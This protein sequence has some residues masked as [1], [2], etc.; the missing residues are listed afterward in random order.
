[1]DKLGTSESLAD[2]SG[3]NPI[4]KVSL[5]HC[6]SIVLS[7]FP[8]DYS[9]DSEALERSLRE[10]INYYRHSSVGRRCLGVVHQINTP[11]QVLSFQLD[12]LEQAAQEELE[13]ISQSP[14]AESE[15]LVTLSIYRQEK[16]RQLRG[17]IEKLRN[18]SRSL[19]LQGMH[20]DIGERI[21]LDL[22]QLC[23]QE[24]D[25]YLTNPIFKHQVTKKF[26]FGDGSLLIYGHYIDFSQSFRN[27]VDNALE[28]MEGMEH[29]H[30]TVVTAYQDGRITLSI[31]DTGVGIPSEHLPWIFEPF[32][33]TKQTPDGPRAGLGLFMVRRLLASYDVE[34]RVDSVPGETWVTLSIP[35]V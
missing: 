17:E 23:R 10:L 11:L 4:P 31:V 33:T 29:R 27:L 14:L 26:H 18:F 9:M 30:L 12:L 7:P 15:K 28:A 25:L 3:P 24:L 19:A 13:L 8:P 32:F 6:H 5:K 16:F 22:N 2:G 35:V 1:M 34:V 20:E 21:H